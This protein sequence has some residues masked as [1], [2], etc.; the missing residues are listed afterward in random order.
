MSNEIIILDFGS[1]YTQL[2][3]RKIREL[4]YYAEIYPYGISYEE[5]SQIRPAG[6][7]LSGGP[8]SVYDANALVIDQRIFDMDIPILGICYGLQLITYQ[9][10]G[11]VHASSEREYGRANLTI[12]KENPLLSG[13]KNNSVVWMSHGDKIDKMPASFVSLAR[14]SNSPYAAIG[15]KTKNI[16]GVQF[17]PEV[18]HTVNGKKILKNFAQKICKMKANWNMKNFAAGKIQEIREI[19]GSEKVLLGLSGGVDSMVTAK[20]LHEALGSRLSCVYVDTGLM[21]ENETE[22]VKKRFR[23]YFS[24]PLHV[25]EAKDVFLSA[26]KEIT[27]PEQKRK[28]IG[29]LFLIEFQKKASFLGHHEF[30]G[31]G[32]LYTDVIESV[33]VKGPSETI[34]SHHNRVQEI[35]DL[36]Q[37]G[38]VI[39][40]LKELFKD[41]VRNLGLELGMPPEILYRHPFPGPGL[42]IRIIGEITEERLSVLRR[43]DFILTEE[44]HRHNFY[45]DIWQAFAVFLPVKTVGVMGDKRT[46][47][48][49]IAL[50]MVT[51]EDGMTSD[52]A[53]LPYEFLGMVSNRIINEIPKINRV[54][55]DISSKPPS[56]IEWE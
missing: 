43:A 37:A 3:A 1:Q 23:D 25:V 20:I 56:T 54:V 8:Y 41:E 12:A 28:I 38:K 50:R 32:T 18:H 29:K 26:L 13:I 19:V 11:K 46:Y 27:D 10:E 53:R 21:R 5:L 39:E 2:I 51:S 7:I 45:G 4:H 47:E 24:I 36:I 33:S 15:H 52:F 31:Q 17:H 6:L 34:K 9:H 16:F 48:N 44:L 42:A 22:E 14:T 35:L 40:P 30:L 55:Y 49:V